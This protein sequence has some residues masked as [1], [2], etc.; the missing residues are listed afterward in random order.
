[1]HLVNLG[2]NAQNNFP[3]IV[4]YKYT[5]LVATVFLGKNEVAEILKHTSLTRGAINR[6]IL[7]LS[8]FINTQDSQ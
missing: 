1:M 7:P 4:F 8:Y 2:G 5:R 6:T 3:F